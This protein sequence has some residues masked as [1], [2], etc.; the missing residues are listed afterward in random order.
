MISASE[1]IKGDLL[2]SCRRKDDSGLATAPDGA[3]ALLVG[4]GVGLLKIVDREFFLVDACE[5]VVVELPVHLVGLSPHPNLVPGPVLVHLGRL[6]LHP[7]VVPLV[8]K[9]LLGALVVHALGGGPASVPYCW[10]ESLSRSWALTASRMPLLTS[11][12]RA[13]RDRRCCSV[14]R[15]WRFCP[16]SITFSFWAWTPNAWLVRW[17]LSR[18]FFWV[19][20]RSSP[21]ACW[22]PD[23]LLVLLLLAAMQLLVVRLLA[24]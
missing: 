22:S 12:F 21:A 3:L 11:L 4:S 24:A 2:L 19:W 23:R 20:S 7:N 15:S 18:R 16:D 13:W 17:M 5:P 9:P 10:T 6:R 1:D 14:S 8:G